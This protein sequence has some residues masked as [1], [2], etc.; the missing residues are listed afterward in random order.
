MLQR[1]R[2][3]DAGAVVANNP[4][5]PPP[6]PQA[7]PAS[8]PGMTPLQPLSTVVTAGG[9]RRPIPILAMATTIAAAIIATNRA[10]QP[11]FRLRPRRLNPRAGPVPV[12]KPSSFGRRWAITGRALSTT[13]TAGISRDP[14][15]RIPTPARTAPS[16]P[17][18][19]RPTALRPDA[20][21][22][23]ERPTTGRPTLNPGGPRP[24]V[25][26]PVHLGPNDN[27][28]T[29]LE[30]VYGTGLVVQ[31][32]R[33]AQSRRLPRLRSVRVGDVVST[34]RISVLQENT[35]T[36]AP[37]SARAPTAQGTAQQV[38]MR[39]QMGA[40][41][42]EV[43]KGDTLFDIARDELGKAS[44]WAEIYEL[45]RDAIGNDVDLLT[46]GTKLRLPGNN[47]D[48]RSDPLTTQSRQ[49]YNR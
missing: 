9:I 48:S 11:P 28:W 40:R 31:G 37:S 6:T 14:D 43:Q 1:G 15:R 46:P 25:P 35:R 24:K 10:I 20:Q 23:D 17:T 34:P 4:N 38:S 12:R 3:N 33:G 45:N 47:G 21:P 8:T 2:R 39:G 16:E 27:Y 7:D 44:R 5:S 22:D 26:R 13:S 49:P 19:E 18:D 30:K 29:I 36:F 42:Y 41:V 32:H